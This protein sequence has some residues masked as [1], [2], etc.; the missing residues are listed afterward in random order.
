MHTEELQ[1]YSRQVL[2]DGF[3]IL[4]QQK[5]KAAHVLIIGAGGLG[6]PVVQS[7]AGMGVGNIGIVDFDKV[8]L[9]N[10]H[11]QTIYKYDD[12]GL[13]KC[14]VAK[15]FA[16][17]LNPFISIE[18]FRTIAS[19]ETLPALVE[20]YN[21][22][23]DCTDNPNSKY[24]IN[25]A[26]IQF[27]KPLVYGSIFKMEGNVSVFNLHANAPTLRC[28]FPEIEPDMPDCNRTG[29]LGL[30]TAQTGICMATE[31]VKIILNEGNIL[32]SQLLIIKAFAPETHIF[33]FEA[34]KRGREQSLK[35]FE[36]FVASFMISPTALQQL[37]LTQ[38]DFDLI[39]VRDEEEH[40]IANIGGKLIPIDE[41]EDRFREISP[42]RN[43][44]VYCHHGIRSQNAVDFLRT[45]GYDKVKNLEGG[46]HAWS[47]EVDETVT[48]Y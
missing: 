13:W 17:A 8:S 1:Y 21:I 48:V 4:S 14:D 30:V 19:H 44:I 23:V 18:T 9:S 26:C 36:S 3:G 5:L 45:A 29:V 47:I 37:F 43:T 22:V 20:N 32:S 7:L 12:I 6:C 31:V 40:A 46:I 33:N 2:L 11:R 41:L 24:L 28:L 42:A 25:D 15:E 27:G 34:T 10:L 38:S 39:D 35:N 16:N